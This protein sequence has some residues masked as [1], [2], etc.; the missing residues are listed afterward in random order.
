M[1]RTLDTNK[2]ASGFL[3]SPRALWVLVTI[4]FVLSFGYALARCP[5]AP[6][7]LVSDSSEYHSLGVSILREHSFQGW[8]FR[9]PGYPAFLATVYSIAGAESLRPV[10]FAQSV[11]LA[12]TLLLVF[13]IAVYLTRDERTSLVAVALCALW[14]PIWLA[15]GA[16]L[17]EIW[18]A[19]LV[20]GSI[21]LLLSVMERPR[22]SQCIGLGL[23]M[24]ATSL[25]K[26]PFLL[27]AAAAL[28]FI[29]L[30]GK[31]RWVRVRY[32]LIVLCAAAVL[33]V[34]W[35]VRNHVVTGACVPIQ[36]GGGMNL[37]LGNRYEYWHS[38]H[39]WGEYP[40]SVERLI[41]GKP[42]VEQERILARLGLD[43]MSQNP[44]RAAGIFLLKFSFLWLGAFGGDP[45]AAE[46]PIPH[47]GRFGIT[48]R[49]VAYVPL[50]MLAV[51]GWFLLP[52][53]ARRRARPIMAL[54]VLWSLPYMITMAVARYTLPVVPYQ[55]VF[56]A[57]ALRRIGGR[58]R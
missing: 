22:V 16:V 35:I 49:S 53:Q 10:Y 23:T 7:L 47:I 50:F 38:H 46:N 42:E 28:V 18:A 52:G 20:A 43:Y 29:V 37:W 19:A 55:L 3:H 31:D 45:N 14:P 6:E 2:L 24:G 54:L 4:S 9:A 21:W 33:V 41:D 17:T 36:T 44:T 39:E 15:V 51:F 32:A 40:D 57:V 13:R 30:S 48:K 11:L 8:V 34:P 5:S 12:I 26:G 25:T 27:F 1:E 56:V 58:R